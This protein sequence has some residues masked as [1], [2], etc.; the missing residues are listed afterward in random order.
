MNPVAATIKDA[1]VN[2]MEES[3][4]YVSGEKDLS[5][6]NI[7][8]SIINVGTN[9]A[10]DALSNTLGGNIVS[11]MG[12]TMRGRRPEKLLSVLQGKQ[13]RKYALKTILETSFGDMLTI[14]FGMQQSSETSN[15]QLIEIELLKD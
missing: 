2:F 10:M 11:S 15:K 7:I 14:P 4:S 12:I 6:T 5:A 13:T 3:K 1:T 9:T 8:D